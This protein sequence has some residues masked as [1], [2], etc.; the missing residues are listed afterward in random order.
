MENELTSKRP[1]DFGEALRHLKAGKKVARAGWH[2]KGMWI[3]AANILAR[4]PYVVIS[5][6]D[7]SQ[8]IGWLCSMT[9]MMAEDWELVE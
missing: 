5:L 6:P 7:G 9:D 8:Q 2:G 1:M 3:F 4:H